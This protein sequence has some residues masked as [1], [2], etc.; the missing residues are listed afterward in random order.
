MTLEP[1]F[2]IPNY[3]HVTSSVVHILML[4]VNSSS[5]YKSVIDTSIATFL[6]DWCNLSVCCPPIQLYLTSP[7]PTQC[8]L[9]SALLCYY[10]QS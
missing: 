2:H 6:G 3:N 1:G 5:N 10:M 7:Y 4:T 9:P 8:Q